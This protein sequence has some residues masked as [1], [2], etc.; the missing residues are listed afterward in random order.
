MIV[1]TTFCVYEPLRISF[2]LLDIAALLY[3]KT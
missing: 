3:N 2:V 1:Q